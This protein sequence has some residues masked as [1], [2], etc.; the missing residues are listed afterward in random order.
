MGDGHFSPAGIDGVHT[1]L[2]LLSTHTAHIRAAGTSTPNNQHRRKQLLTL[3][4]LLGILGYQ[5]SNDHHF[6]L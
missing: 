6:G 2:V 5:S 4:M 3:K 1:C